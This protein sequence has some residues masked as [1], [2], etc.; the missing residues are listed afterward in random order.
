[1]R[2]EETFWRALLLLW[3]IG[4]QVRLG[5]HG[6]SAAVKREGRPKIERRSNILRPDACRIGSPT[7]EITLPDVVS[8]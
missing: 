6:V 4:M 7:T 8:Y 5:S 2:E 3:W 1:M